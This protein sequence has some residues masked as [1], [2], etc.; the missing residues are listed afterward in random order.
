MWRRRR[1]LLLLMLVLL[2]FIGV[3]FLIFTGYHLSA[4]AINDTHH[5]H[6]GQCQY[7]K[8]Q[9]F[10]S[11]EFLATL[12]VSSQDCCAICWRHE[13]CVAWTLHRGACWLKD[14]LT[15]PLNEPGRGII[16]G[17]LIDSTRQALS[18]IKDH[19]KH[20]TIVQPSTS[21]KTNMC[22]VDVANKSKKIHKRILFTGLAYEIN[23]EQAKNINQTF[24]ELGSFFT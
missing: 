10:A 6:Q 3:L 24:N 16:S 21:N 18:C 19:M 23:N 4:S 20:G 7:Y 15:K 1:E 17:R 9:S 22:N 8:D 5:E 12:A 2:F 14:E 13:R 11:G